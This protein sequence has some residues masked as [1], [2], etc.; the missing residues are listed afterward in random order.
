MQPTTTRGIL[1]GPGVRKRQLRLP[2]LPQTTLLHRSPLKRVHQERLLKSLHKLYQVLQA[3]RL[4]CPHRPLHRPHL[5]LWPQ[6]L[7]SIHSTTLATIKPMGQHTRRTQLTRA[8]H[9]HKHTH[10]VT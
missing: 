10:R 5:H 1:K 3:Q 4:L 8:T 6:A 7:K 9:K 2:P